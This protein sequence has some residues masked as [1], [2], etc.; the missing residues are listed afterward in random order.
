MKNLTLWDLAMGLEQMLDKNA[1][2][3][4][5]LHAA[6]IYG[7]ALREKRDE[8]VVVFS[9]GEQGQTM[10]LA[11]ELKV[12]DIDHD[13]AGNGF[14][15]HLLSYVQTPGVPADV[16]DLAQRLIDALAPTPSD[17]RR[18][19]V[20]E[21]QAAKA[22][23]A[24]L[25]TY[26]AD[27][28]RF[29]TADGRT[30]YDWYVAFLDAADHIQ[31]LLQKRVAAFAAHEDLVKIEGSPAAATLRLKTLKLLNRFRKTVRDE[32]AVRRELP[33]GLETQLFGYLDILQSTRAPS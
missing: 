27:L 12:A 5:S 24:L 17:L 20:D 31:S 10:P 25:P 18:A 1:G 4:A 3:F 15:G 32:M 16:R 28:R 14:R 29:P 9:R 6:T 11:P 8:I 22:R 21:A 30:L 26:E 7:P 2:S 33:G 23:R 19:Y 13:G